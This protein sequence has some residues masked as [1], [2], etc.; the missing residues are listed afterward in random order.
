MTIQEKIDQLANAA[1]RSAPPAPSLPK[2]ATYMAPFDKPK[3]VALVAAPDSAA[4]PVP[5]T[6]AAAVEAPAAPFK[7]EPDPELRAQIEEREIVLAKRHKRKSL[8]VT[9][10]VLAVLGSASFWCYQSPKARAEIGALIPALRQSVD[11]V[12]MIGSITKKYD[13]QLEKI[14]VHG[15]Q[16]NEAT[17]AMGIDPAS[18]SPE[19]N[20]E[21]EAEMA[22]M[23]GEEGPT[24]GERDRAIKEKF[25][26][27]GKLAGRSGNK[28]AAANQTMP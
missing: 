3:T 24:T 5:V 11:D 10:G 13:E 22:K 1:I 9:L 17:R 27:I 26:I 4:E 2:P 8:A 7:D 28:P 19:G 6:A 14:A 16:I 21:I 18:A 20:A 12:K 23:M 15:D 25:G